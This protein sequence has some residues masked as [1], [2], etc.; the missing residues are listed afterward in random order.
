MTKSILLLPAAAL[1]WLACQN[2][3]AQQAAAPTAS[4]ILQHKYWVSKPFHDALFA[5]NI[6]DTLAY[7]PCGEL[8]FR[9]LDT[10]FLTA[11]LSDTGLGKYKVTSDSTLE[12]AVEGFEGQPATVRFDK[13]TGILHFQLPGATD[14]GWPMAYVAHDDIDAAAFDAAAVNLGRKRLA[15]SY[16]VLPA[17]GEA[18]VTALVELRADG[19]QVGLGDFDAYEPW[20]SG[21]G[22]AFI[23]EPARNLMY[24]VKNSEAETPTAVAWQVRGDT[25]RIWDT[26]NIGAEGDLPEYR[27]DKLKGVYVKTK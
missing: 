27:V 13:A 6:V 9:N 1:C 18:T 8:V 23:Q 25:L 7:L 14:A 4:A 24:L 15:G 3:P 17:P 19:T 11:C 21:A 2:P 5:E 26:K 20:P 16:T 12:I 10:V 22:S